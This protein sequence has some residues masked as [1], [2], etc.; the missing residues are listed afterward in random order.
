LFISGINTSIPPMNVMDKNGLHISFHF[1]RQDKI[2]IIHLQ[3]TNS[4]QIPITNFVFKAA[5]P[6]V[7]QNDI[8][9]DLF[10]KKKNLFFL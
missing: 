10:T 4:T 1:E 5:V 3:A 8:L 6:K 2:L 9:L 7:I